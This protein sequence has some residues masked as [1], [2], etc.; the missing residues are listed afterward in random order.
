MYERLALD[1]ALWDQLGCLSPVALYVISPEGRVPDAVVEG[2]CQALDAAEKRM[3]R[4]FVPT[5]AA[6][7]ITNERGAAEMRAASGDGASVHRGSG[8]SWTVAVEGN[9][10]WR[11]SPLYR[12]LRVHPVADPAELVEA[13]RPV[14][15][16][17]AAAGLD[18]FGVDTAAVARALVGLGASRICR[19]GRFQSP[20]L[21][22]CHD[23]QGVLLPL[24]RLG[25]VESG[26]PSTAR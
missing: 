8:T 19:F 21:D 23:N 4:G 1:V 7:Q 18:G 17:L 11:T 16:H 14:S 12:F 20:P 13:L 2:L 9:A 5:E 10:R 15:P 22:W 6:A 26:A 3:P 24:A 25:D